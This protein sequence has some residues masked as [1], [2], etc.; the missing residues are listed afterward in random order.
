[1]KYVILG[2]CAFAQLGAAPLDV[3]VS[4]QAATAAELVCVIERPSP[5]WL[6]TFVKDYVTTLVQSTGQFQ[7][8]IKEIETAQKRQSIEQLADAGF[9]LALFFSADDHESITWRLYDTISVAQVRGK[10]CARGQQTLAEWA[11]SVV[12][13]FWADLTGQ[14][15][16]F[17]SLIAACRQAPHNKKRVNNELYLLHPFFGVQQFGYIKLAS[18]N[19]FAP[20]WHANKA[21]VF[22]SQH[23]PFNVRLMAV[24]PEMISQVIMNREGQNMT[25][26]I[27]H[28]GRVVL[29]L[30]DNDQVRLYEYRFDK[31]LKKSFLT[32]LTHGAGDFISPSFVDDWR[33]VFCHVDERNM[34]RLGLLDIG[35]HA[36]TWVPVGNALSPS[37]HQATHRIAYSK[38]IN[39]IYQLFMYDCK[40]HQ[41][42]QLTT[43]VM[44]KDECSWS[45]CGNYI[46]CCVQTAT[47]SRI[48]II[49]VWDR[50]MRFLTPVNQR[51][52]Y[53]SWSPVQH[54]PFLFR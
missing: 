34:P 14:P 10:Q 39:G 50:R 17:A 43:D 49:D 9:G 11:I 8:T 22:Y 48:A 12:D 36:I 4:A 44:D 38:K 21:V 42:S 19:N 40:N 27:A 16:S 32:C 37:A 3:I 53:P 54:V 31:T 15:S 45:P 6:H 46:A 35:T 52:S 5:G 13:G 41:E 23:T 18:G 24:Y 33:V 1:M 29:A 25:P 26:A 20:R 51:W 2:L 30:S 28:D 7:V 47:K